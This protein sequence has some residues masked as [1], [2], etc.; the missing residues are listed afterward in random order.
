MSAQNRL[1][2]ALVVAGLLL[3]GCGG[4]NDDAPAAAAAAAPV[5]A[6]APS[7]TP[8]AAKVAK[9]AKVTKVSAT[10]SVGP[11]VVVP[12]TTDVKSQEIVAGDWQSRVVAALRRVDAR[13]VI[14]Q[15]A[16]V[17]KVRATCEQMETGMFST[18]VI[19]IIEKRFS[20]KELTVT[21]GMA[22]DIYSVLLQDACY[23]M[24]ES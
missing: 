8:K 24:H 20:S 4:S 23:N 19:P 2:A 21:H 15:P 11:E 7:A 13:L 3:T 22:Q 10:P 16:A 6:A 17:K 9:V 12:S 18:K 1:P 5:A 14:D